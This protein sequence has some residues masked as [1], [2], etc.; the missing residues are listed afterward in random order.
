MQD[1]VRLQQPSS[2]SCWLRYEN[3]RKHFGPT[4]LNT[5]QPGH[6]LT[7]RR[8]KQSFRGSPEDDGLLLILQASD[9]VA[10]LLWPIQN[11]LDLVAILL[12]QAAL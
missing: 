6:C 8:Q 9:S 1:I 2:D 3:Q 12:L 4:A 11:L 7:G 5:Q 10:I